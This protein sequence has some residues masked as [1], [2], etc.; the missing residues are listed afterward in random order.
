MFRRPP[1]VLLGAIVT[2]QGVHRIE[3]VG[4]N[5][6]LIG[7]I[8]LHNAELNVLQNVKIL[9]FHARHAGI[10]RPTAS[11]GKPRPRRRSTTSCLAR[12]SSREAVDPCRSVE[13]S[14][15][16]FPSPYRA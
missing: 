11:A 8:Y 14:R 9:F 2:N 1:S 4:V 3:S 15:V 12:W 5:Q 13:S 6:V 7:A 16:F 10:L